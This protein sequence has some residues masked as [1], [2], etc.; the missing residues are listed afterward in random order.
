MKYYPKNRIKENLYTRGGEYKLSS[1][2]EEYVG[3]Y[4]KLYT[5]EL[6]TGSTALDTPNI[7]LIPLKET[8]KP[9]SISSYTLYN[10]NSETNKKYLKQKNININR[11][12][13]LPISYYV[14]LN[15]EDYSRGEITRYFLKKRN[16]LLYIEVNKNTFKNITE[17]NK[18]WVW[19]I[20]IPFEIKWVITGNKNEVFRKNREEVISVMNFLTL[21]KFDIFL[22][23][24]YTEFL[25]I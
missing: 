19:E 6:Y 17:K 21:P 1:K 10:L 2:D 4:H 24:N 14:K 25:Q 8:N 11:R 22:N 18:N 23:K 3:Y 9:E 13:N 12:R 5:G 16:E 20:Y 7:Q 15:E